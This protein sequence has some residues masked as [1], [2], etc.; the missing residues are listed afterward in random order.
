MS[1][2]AELKTSWTLLQ[3]K[4]ELEEAESGLGAI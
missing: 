3:G 4:R 2:E 1:K